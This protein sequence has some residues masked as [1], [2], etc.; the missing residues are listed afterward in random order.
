M[1]VCETMAYRSKT[2][3]VRQPP[4]PWRWIPSLKQNRARVPREKKSDEGNDHTYAPLGRVDHEEARD[5]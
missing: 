3:R 5:Q 4:R 2:L 1:S